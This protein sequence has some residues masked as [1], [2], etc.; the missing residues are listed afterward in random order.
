VAQAGLRITAGQLLLITAGLGLALGA[1]GAWLRGPL[2]GLLGAAGGAAAPL[3]AVHARRNARRE[4]FQAQLPNAFDLM[5]R[6]L[7]AGQSVPAALQAVAD[8]LSG[9]VATEF[10]DCQKRQSLGL[11]PEVTFQELA[12]RTGILEVRIFVMALLIQ[13]QVG[14]NLAEVLERLAGLVRERQRLRLRVRSLTAEGRL[15]GLTLLVLPFVLFGA[16]LFVNRSYAEVLFDHVGLLAATGAWMG[17]G[18]LWIRRI[19]NFEV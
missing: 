15:Q 13:R 3:L 5:A 8:S 2:T 1:A 16:L 19:V 17:V 18:V 7:R 6:V 9:P 11:R 14:G 12:E 10:G 4:K